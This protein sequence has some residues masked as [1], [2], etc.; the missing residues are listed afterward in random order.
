[1]ELS[2]RTFLKLGA[3]VPSAIALRLPLVQPEAAGH[4]SVEPLGCVMRHWRDELAV[5][6]AGPNVIVSPG[7]GML[8]K[9]KDIF[10]CFYENSSALM[11]P[12]Q[13]PEQYVV[14]RLGD[15]L[16]RLEAVDEV[17]ET[18]ML[19]ARVYD[20]GAGL[21]VE[22]WREWAEYRGMGP[23]SYDDLS[24]VEWGDELSFPIL[25][26]PW[27]TEPDIVFGGDDAPL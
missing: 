24:F 19:L 14:V 17:R 25:W 20:T 6:P 10:G 16:A 21:V 4:S 13:G 12:I 1:M 23:G 15:G 18:D 5:S 7:A 3:I 22:D 2:R 27:P 11:L 8:K 9:T 26:R